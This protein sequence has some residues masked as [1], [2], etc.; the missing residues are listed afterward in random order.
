MKA[1]GLILAG[2]RS[3]RF[4]S[5]KAVA[6]F[7]GSPMI[8][9]VATALLAGCEALAVNARE[10]SGAA[11]WALA[12]R[13]ALLPDAPDDHDGPLAGVRQGLRWASGL[14]AHALI[15]APCDTPRLAHS[16]VTRLLEGLAASPAAYAVSPES[17]H[18]LCSA[19]RVDRLRPLE[20][21]LVEGHP[22]VRRL[23]DSWNAA[24]IGFPDA[25][26]FANV[27]TPAQ[28]SSLGKTAP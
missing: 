24:P 13:H 28:A 26:A 9:H 16:T 6:P 14:G 17:A 4:G 20:A 1:C 27:N 21:V 12:G 23:L 2:G 11:A 15:V 25:A 10:G 8:A 3:S 19:W 18:P 5:E 22:S 7:E